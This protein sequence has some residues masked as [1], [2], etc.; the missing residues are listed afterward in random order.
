MRV[1]AKPWT[2]AGLSFAASGAIVAGAHLSWR[3]CAARL[4]GVH[5]QL[6]LLLG[7]LSLS[8]TSIVPGKV[9][10]LGLGLSPL[11]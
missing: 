4:W 7:G 3:D 8:Q 11:L 9:N 2:G 1:I 10:L 6:R 5:L